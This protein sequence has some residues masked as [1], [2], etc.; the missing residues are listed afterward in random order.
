[1]RF[2]FDLNII[3]LHSKTVI[4]QIYNDF[5]LNTIDI[6]WLMTHI[7]DFF[8]TKCYGLQQNISFPLFFEDL[9]TFG[10]KKEFLKKLSKIY[11]F[12]DENLKKEFWNKIDEINKIRNDFAHRGY[13]PVYDDINKNIKYYLPRTIKENGIKHIQESLLQKKDIIHFK[14]LFESVN[15]KLNELSEKISKT[16]KIKLIEEKVTW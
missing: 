15:K 7:F 12:F 11:T 9:Q 13:S 4:Y 3:D 14:E 10:N 5:M 8:L 2:D 1:M 6:E 16:E